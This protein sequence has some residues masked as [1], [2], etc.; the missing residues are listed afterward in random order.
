M[1]I[2]MHNRL[3]YFLFFALALASCRKDVDELVIREVNYT[4]PVISVQGNLT[5]QVVGENG[6]PI[7]GASVAMGNLTTTTNEAGLFRFRNATLNAG[8]TYV[9]VSQPGYFPGSERFFPLPN[10][11]NAI[12]IG[13]I[14]R[15]IVGSVSA[16]AGG[17]VALAN[18]AKVELPANGIMDE[19]GAPYNGTV[20]VAA[21]WLNP[22]ADNLA[23]IMPGNLQ[24]V[25]L[26][27][28]EVSMAS[29]GM[30]AVELQSPDGRKLQVATGKRAKLTFPLPADFRAEAPPTSPLW[31]FDE[32]LGLWVEE[33][34][35]RLQDGT[36]V[37]EVAHFSFWNCDLPFP[38]VNITGTL[39]LNNGGPAAGQQLIATANNL[40]IAAGTF[41]NANGGFAGKVPK[42]EPLTLSV[43]T[44][45][46]WSSINIGPFSEDTNLG[47][48]NINTPD[49]VST[50]SGRLVDCDNNP[51]TDGAVLL[52]WQDHTYVMPIAAD[53]TFN[54]DVVYCTTGDFSLVG[55]DFANELTS[56]AETFTI[57][58][59]VNAGDISVCDAPLTA[60]MIV[61]INGE[62]VTMVV[63]ELLTQEVDFDSSGVLELFYGISGRGTTSDGLQREFTFWIKAP[64]AEGPYTGESLWIN[65]VD[66]F[67][68]GGVNIYK[69][70][71]CS[72]TCDSATL[73]LTDVGDVGEMITGTVSGTVNFY[74][75]NQQQS[76]LPIS[77]N[78]SILRTE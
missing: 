13:L 5:G 74:D 25:D 3:L 56:D 73:A 70:Y 28:R 4:P 24:G 64:L 72:P 31:Y 52:S 9:R 69:V 14:P 20:Q 27:D 57:G 65:G 63:T 6:E 38:L 62:A 48:V 76:Q 51:V 71:Y 61:D 29:F 17:V 47:T 43:W 50:I 18:G 22:D 12:R 60:Y 32:T 45:C 36:Y 54:G 37:G 34:E 15:R 1:Y 46:G 2:I 44:A 33:G 58:A 77:A 78:F 67:T 42:D 40:N 8:G 7:V 21:H 49:Q 11:N 59:T 55:Y 16:S 19:N 30:M 10:A 68:G 39:T 75:N 41:T 66:R 53:G 23:D 26:N 35:A